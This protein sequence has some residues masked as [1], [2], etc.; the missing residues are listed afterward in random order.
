MLL[1]PGSVNDV[2]SGTK[3]ALPSRLVYIASVGN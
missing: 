2:I 3:V 1:R